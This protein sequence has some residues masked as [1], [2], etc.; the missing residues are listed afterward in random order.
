MPAELHNGHSQNIL[1]SVDARLPGADMLAQPAENVIEQKC[2]G[3]RIKGL[4]QK[5]GMGLVELG[6][7]TGLSASFLSQLETGRVV[8]TLRNLA[9]IALVFSRGINYFFESERGEV[10][11]ILRASERARLPQGGATVPDYFFESLG[12]VPDGSQMAPYVAEFLPEDENRS[13]RAHQ[14][15]GAEFLYV[16]TGCLQIAHGE[17]SETFAAGDAVYFHSGTTHSYQRLGVDPCTA[18]ILTMP[19]QLQTKPRKAARL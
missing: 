1:R 15:T 16:L 3:D 10:F 7:H 14:H 6:R 18:L 17:H 5:K 13:Q 2:I 12:A 4:R 9:R 11:S 19:V 8:P